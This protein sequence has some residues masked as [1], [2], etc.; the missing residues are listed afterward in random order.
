MTKAEP[1][2]GVL[3]VGTLCSRI[4]FFTS[5]RLFAEDSLFFPSVFG[6]M[7][8]QTSFACLSCEE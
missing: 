7:V 4:A 1:F 5:R 3:T 8:V 2:S 6:G